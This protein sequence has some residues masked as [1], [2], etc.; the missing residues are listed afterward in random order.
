MMTS[1]FISGPWNKIWWPGSTGARYDVFKS[2]C[3]GPWAPKEATAALSA[4]FGHYY[5]MIESRIQ[6]I[7]F[8]EKPH[9]P[10]CSPAVSWAWA[11]EIDLTN[12]C[13]QL[14]PWEIGQLCGGN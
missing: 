2:Q 9:E 3:Y 12:P 13:C 11:P 14:E 10:K 6:V 7:G 5:M 8:T 4:A 1:T